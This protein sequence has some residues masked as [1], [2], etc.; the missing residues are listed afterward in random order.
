MQS[1]IPQR[2]KLFAGQATMNVALAV[3]PA[4]AMGG[5]FH[6]PGLRH[7]RL[8]VELKE[9]EGRLTGRQRV[10]G[11]ALLAGMLLA[12]AGF[13]AGPRAMGYLGV[14]WSSVATNAVLFLPSGRGAIMVAAALV[15]N[16]F[17]V[18]VLT[19]IGGA[20]GE[21]TGYALGHSSRGLVKPVKTPA[22]LGRNVERHMAVSILAVSI[23]PNPFVDV[24]GIIAGRL[25]YPLVSFL[26]YSVIGKV[27]QSIVF[28]YLALWNI[29]LIGSWVGLDL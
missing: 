26:V 16:P 13:A 10:L 18:A 17:T 6:G 1:T 3:Q 23:I 20:L 7:S 25:G 29:S 4:G 27:L 19:G 28:V 2:S 14:F 15:L 21:I 9:L 11:L 8:Y 5:T 12:V 24:I 22:W